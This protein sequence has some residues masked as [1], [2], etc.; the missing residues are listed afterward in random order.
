MTNLTCS[1]P[2][3]QKVRLHDGAMRIVARTAL[4]EHYRI[5]SMDL[6]KPIPLVTIE[7]ATFEHKT[8]TLIQAVTLGALHARNRRMLVERLKVRGRIRA[9]KETH[10]L[11]AALPRENQR[12][13]AWGG[14]H[15]GMQH[16]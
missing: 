15:A 16:I 13:H 4:F 7:T 2:G 10:F 3:I 6:G 8:A 5:M 12:V 1:F 11:L 14:V 9:N